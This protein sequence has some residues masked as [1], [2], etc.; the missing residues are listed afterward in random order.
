MCSE[1][2]NSAK[3]AALSQ[4]SAVAPSGECQYIVSSRICVMLIEVDP[5]RDPDQHQKIIISRGSLF[6]HAYDVRSTSVNAFVSYSAH[7]QTDR[8]TDGQTDRQT[9]R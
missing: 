3:A 9:V 2:A 6:V 4:R 8:Q 7:R 1:S 5:H